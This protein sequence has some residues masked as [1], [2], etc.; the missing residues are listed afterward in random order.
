MTASIPGSHHRRAESLCQQLARPVSLQE[1]AAIIARGWAASI[2]AMVVDLEGNDGDRDY[3]AR[4]P[5]R[6]RVP[7]AV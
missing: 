7:E 1:A 2:S 4:F 3:R 6:V 5:R